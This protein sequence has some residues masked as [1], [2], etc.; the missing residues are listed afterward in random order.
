VVKVF[1]ADLDSTEIRSHQK[2][3]T[4]ETLDSPRCSSRPDTDAESDASAER[5][6]FLGCQLFDLKL[7][8]FYLFLKL[9]LRDFAARPG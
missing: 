6:L 5:C 1:P 9:V 7:F 8:F 2:T 3:H 4:R